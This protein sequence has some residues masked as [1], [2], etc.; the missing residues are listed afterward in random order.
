[1][2][3]F[4]SLLSKYLFPLFSTQIRTQLK[5]KAYEDAGL[6]PPSAAAVAKTATQAK[7]VTK[8]QVVG[9]PQTKKHKP[10]GNKKCKNNFHFFTMTPLKIGVS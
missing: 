4:K 5:R 3:T 10:S 7:I 2:D 9:E 6:Q 8:V 1:M